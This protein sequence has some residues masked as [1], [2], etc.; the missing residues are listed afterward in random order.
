[1]SDKRYANHHMTRRVEFDSLPYAVS[2]R[3]LRIAVGIFLLLLGALGMLAIPLS[4]P[5]LPGLRGGNLL[6][7][8]LTASAGIVIWV[9]AAIYITR[10]VSLKITTETVSYSFRTLGHREKWS[11]PLASYQGVTLYGE[12]VLEGLV[13]HVLLVHSRADR[14]ILL[15]RKASEMKAWGAVQHFAQVLNLPAIESDSDAQSVR[16]TEDIG[17]SVR[18]LYA[19]GKL[20]VD[21]DSS[22]PAPRH[23]DVCEFPGATE[24]RISA[25]P[26]IAYPLIC[27]FLAVVF[28]ISAYRWPIF[29][30]E[31]P[32]II[33][34]VYAI[35][36][37]PMWVW[38]VIHRQRLRFSDGA[39]ELINEL[40]SITW[41][42]ASM[43]LDEILAVSISAQRELADKTVILRGSSK[44]IRIGAWLNQK[45][46]CWLRSYLLHHIT[47]S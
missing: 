35:C 11:E 8:V 14:S 5:I 10:G 33:C 2:D 23:V 13:Y 45:D 38:S 19:E 18:Q 7:A 40:V 27:V 31:Y 24:V 42:K 47:S 28:S 30:L 21:F 34:L 4:S 12:M 16:E 9:I 26:H 36:A 43:N 6:E 29:L 46:L 37:V 44:S 22:S 3:T 1:M 20:E 17:K 15:Q 32:A 39:V 25:S 41:T